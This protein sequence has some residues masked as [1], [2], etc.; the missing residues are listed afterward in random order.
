MN[1]PHPRTTTSLRSAIAILLATLPSCLGS[2]QPRAAAEHAE[3]EARAAPAETGGADRPPTPP[4]GHAVLRPEVETFEI[5]REPGLVFSRPPGRP[6]LRLD[7]FLPVAPGPHPVAIVIP[8]GG[9]RS[10]NRGQSDAVG[11]ATALAHEGV[12]AAAIGHRRAPRD[13]YP[14]ALLDCRAALRFLRASAAQHEL[15]SDRIVAIGCS[16]GGH[17]AALLGTG[18]SATRPG[19][20][21]VV[22]LSAPLDLASEAA[23]ANASGLQMQLV[24][25]FV[26]VPLRLAG[27]I[28][29]AKFIER[30]RAKARAASPIE[31]IPTDAPPFLLIH[32]DAD[33]IVPVDQSRRM[34]RALLERG[35]DSS[36]HIEA[37]RGHVDYRMSPPPRSWH[38]DGGPPFVAAIRN[39]VRPKISGQD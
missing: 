2:Q 15:D 5:R 22:A 28:G 38:L 13:P 12:A 26:G 33:T 30:V 8:G 4:A 32:G 39:F 18:P 21:A 20:R 17:L 35:V 19:L 7:L 1:E 11:L 36:L 27:E 14:A 29:P 31:A 6:A 9:W 37:G 10:G 25:D 34:H 3:G 16:S 23:V 24:A